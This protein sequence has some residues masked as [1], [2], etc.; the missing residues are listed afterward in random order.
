MSL[1]TEAPAFK[2]SRAM[3]GRVVSTEIGTD[4]LAAIAPTAGTTLRHSSSGE[5]GRDPGRVDSPP[6]SRRSAPS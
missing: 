2:A 3:S 6:M 1:T 5:T 4:T